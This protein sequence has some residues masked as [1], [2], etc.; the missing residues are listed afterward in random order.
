MS[1]SRKIVVSPAPAGG[2]DTN[3]VTPFDDSAGSQSF[4]EAAAA[5]I[6]NNPNFPNNQAQSQQPETSNLQRANVEAFAGVLTN[7]PTASDAKSDHSSSLSSED[8]DD[9]G[10][11]EGIGELVP[12]VA[13]NDYTNPMKPAGKSS[14]TRYILHPLLMLVTVRVF[15]SLLHRYVFFILML[16]GQ[17]KKRLL[18]NLRASPGWALC[19]N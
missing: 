17:W 6:S 3:K 2:S 5:G 11:N 16:T 4:S 13:R 19:Q 14:A 7:P 18:R 12:V 10:D 8:L 1:Q 9:F 15:N